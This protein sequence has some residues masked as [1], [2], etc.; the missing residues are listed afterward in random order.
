M[1]QRKVDWREKIV[2]WWAAVDIRQE[3]TDHTVT[4]LTLHQSSEKPTPTVHHLQV[5][6]TLLH[7]TNIRFSYTVHLTFW[8]TS[9]CRACDN[10]S[11]SS[12]YK[13]LLILMWNLHGN[14]RNVC[15]LLQMVCDVV[16]NVNCGD[17]TRS[18]FLGWTTESACGGLGWESSWLS[19]RSMQ[20][21]T[22]SA[23]IQL[24]HSA[25]AFEWHLKTYKCKNCSLYIM[26]M[27]TDQ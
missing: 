4:H 15:P 19:V 25:P 3:W 2:C 17:L 16:Q 20:C 24:C 10:H 27:A 14:D 18:A 11:F 6:L 23:N 21:L 1:V 9:R 22:S 26:L 12:L 8:I 13:C 5:F 7:L